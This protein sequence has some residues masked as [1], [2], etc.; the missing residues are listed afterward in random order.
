MAGFVQ[1][2]RQCLEPGFADLQRQILKCPLGL[3]ELVVDSDALLNGLKANLA[4]RN[5]V[6]IG[7]HG[8]DLSVRI[9]I[10]DLQLR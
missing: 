4:I 8:I 1:L 9:V 6:R 3:A 2:G 5:A 10:I 7:I